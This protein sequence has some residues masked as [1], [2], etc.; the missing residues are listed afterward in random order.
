[1][2]IHGDS[3]QNMKSETLPKFY[4]KNTYQSIIYGLDFPSLYIETQSVYSYVHKENIIGF[5]GTE[6]Y[7]TKIS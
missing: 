6:H 4:S 1:M 2:G 3:G 7:E 5:L